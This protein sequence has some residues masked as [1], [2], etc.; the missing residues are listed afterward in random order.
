VSTVDRELRVANTLGLH[1]RAAALIVQ[2]AARFR[3]QL[4]LF[5]DGRRVNGK[6]IMGVMSLAAPKGSRGKVEIEGDD[7]LELLDALKALFK[8]RFHED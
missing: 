1:A 3:S 5:K 6:S 7:A 8:D 4:W 2:T